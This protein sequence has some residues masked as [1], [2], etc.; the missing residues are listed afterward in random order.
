MPRWVTNFFR[1]TTIIA[2]GWAL[3][4]LLVFPRIGVLYGVWRYAHS[5]KLILGVGL[6]ALLI[7]LGLLYAAKQLITHWHPSRQTTWLVLGIELGVYV[8]VLLFVLRWCGYQTPVDDAAAVFNWVHSGTKVAVW[9][10]PTWL[11]HYMYANPQNLFL[12]LIYAGLGL[13]FGKAFF[14]VVVVFVLIQ[15]ATVGLTMSTLH[16]FKCEPIVAWLVTQVWFI[17]LQVWLHAAIAYTDTLLLF[18][19]VASLYALAGWTD[20]KRRPAARNWSLGWTCL[21]AFLAYLSKGTGLIYVI[22][23]AVYLCASQ[24]GLRRLLVFVPLLTL[25]LGNVA[26]HQAINATGIYPDHNYGQPNTHYVM[27]GLSHTPVPSGLSVR[28]QLRWPV[29]IFE[30]ADQQY[31]WRLFYDQKLSK[32]TIQTKQLQKAKQRLTAMT[33]L[34]LLVALNDKVSVVWGSGDVKASASI[35]AGMAHPDRGKLLFSSTLI[36]TLTYLMMTVSQLL[37]YLSIVLGSFKR[38]VDGLSLITL[39]GYFL[40]M[41]LWEANPRYSLAIVPF[42]LL[43][44]A[45]S[46]RKPTES[47]LPLN[48]NR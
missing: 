20:Q 34:G 46:W 35:E 17:A 48:F 40:F 42:A 2:F 18:F 28:D 32:S 19:I 1:G 41:L 36:G 27:M 45:I 12:A 6:L 16:R 3:I 26:W 5:T 11:N 21:L 29:G 33:P 15:A 25:G 38:S 44:L 47:T 9:Q 4:S 14:P 7:A 31:S 30:S 39:S 24:K 23:L 43:M 13:I 10:Q 22:G 8:V 37:L